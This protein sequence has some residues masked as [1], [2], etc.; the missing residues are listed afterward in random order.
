MQFTV[1]KFLGLF[2]IKT[3]IKVIIVTHFVG[4]YILI[5]Y[6]LHKL[7]QLYEAVGINLDA[8][9]YRYDYYGRRR[10]VSFWQNSYINHTCAQGVDVSTPPNRV[11]FK[12][13]TQEVY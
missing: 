8:H 1:E 6:A 11:K 13:L 9:Y 5:G 3:G 12:I 7:V 4:A 2:S 10:N